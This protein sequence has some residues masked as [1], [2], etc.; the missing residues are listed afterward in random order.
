[1]LNL[2]GMEYLDLLEKEE[3]LK[4]KIGKLFSNG[5]DLT[6]EGNMKIDSLN[7]KLVSVQDRINEIRAEQ[8]R[9]NKGGGDYMNDVAKE[10]IRESIE[11]LEMQLHD[12]YLDGEQEARENEVEELDKAIEQLKA[13]L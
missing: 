4:E 5:A 7:E 8:A 2:D 1:M 6:T 11:D 9:K 3:Q 12:I 13:L 10:S